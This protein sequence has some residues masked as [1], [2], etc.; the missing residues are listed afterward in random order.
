[1]NSAIATS[2][3]EGSLLGKSIKRYFLALAITISTAA[4]LSLVRQKEYA[5]SMMVSLSQIWEIAVMLPLIAG[6]AGALNL[7]LN[8]A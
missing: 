6:F 4:L 2:S 5:T 7:V 3:G 1:M 8:F